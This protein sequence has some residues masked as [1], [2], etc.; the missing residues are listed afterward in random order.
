MAGS[1]IKALYLAKRVFPSVFGL[2]SFCDDKENIE[3]LP[4]IKTPKR[5]KSFISSTGLITQIVKSSASDRTSEALQKYCPRKYFNQPL[6]EDEKLSVVKLIEPSSIGHER[7][8]SPVLISGS[9]LSIESKAKMMSPKS[10]PK[11]LQFTCSNYEIEAYLWSMIHSYG[12]GHWW[13]KSSNNEKVVRQNIAKIIKL[14]RFEK[15]S[16]HQ[17]LQDLSISECFSSATSNVKS[18]A[19]FHDFVWWFYNSFIGS[20]IQVFCFLMSIFASQYLPESAKFQ[21]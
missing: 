14:R 20:L 16:L 18:L 6:T 8:S 7:K 3:R 5:L 17:L 21:P 12:F 1:H 15:I 2:K 4:P 19:M 11:F 9:N 13:G 10:K